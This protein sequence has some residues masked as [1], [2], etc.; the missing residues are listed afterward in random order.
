MGD[1]KEVQKGVEKLCFVANKSNYAVCK[2]GAG[3]A[4]KKWEKGVTSRER[5][6]RKEKKISR[7]VGALLIIRVSVFE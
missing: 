4:T 6:K 3:T 7:E 5:K 1:G 2:G